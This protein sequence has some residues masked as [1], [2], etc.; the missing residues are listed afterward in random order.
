MTGNTHTNLP[1]IGQS[2]QQPSQQLLTPY[3]PATPQA[4]PGTQPVTVQSEDKRWRPEEIN[5]FDGSS[6]KVYA[7]TDRLTSVATKKGVQMVQ[8]NLVTLFQETAWK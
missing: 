2:S 5:Y 4:V 7:F 1:A 8:S 6:D 3:P